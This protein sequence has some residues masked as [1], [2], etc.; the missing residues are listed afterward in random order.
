M[1]EILVL[2]AD[3]NIKPNLSNPNISNWKYDNFGVLSYFYNR[4]NLTDSFVFFPF[5]SG[6]IFVFE[7]NTKTYLKKN[8]RKL[9]RKSNLSNI[10]KIKIL[11]LLK[12]SYYLV[13]NKIYLLIFWFKKNI[14]FILIFWN[15]LN[16]L[17]SS[18]IRRIN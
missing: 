9:E 5:Y 14:N 15:N 7:K 6:I 16:K 3:T 10:I 1:L 2:N 18:I 12:Y 8:L 17:T 13:L 11:N 4:F